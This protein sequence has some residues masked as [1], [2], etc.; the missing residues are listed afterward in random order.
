[1]MVTN[2]RRQDN[3][4]AYIQQKMQA[5]AAK[6]P[7]LLDQGERLSKPFQPTDR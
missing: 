6:D 1:M 7:L 2:R 5:V 4:D 3:N